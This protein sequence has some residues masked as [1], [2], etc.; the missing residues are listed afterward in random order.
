MELITTEDL[1]AY[2][3]D[4]SVT[5]DARA[6]LV[7]RLTNDLITEKWLSPVD[8]APASVLILA[9]AVASRARTN[10]P[11]RGP[12]QSITRSFDD[13]SRT[14]RFAVPGGEAS[15]HDVYLT[16][17]ELALLN[18]GTKRRRVGSIKLAVPGY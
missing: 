8:P 14:E 4:D 11:G 1:A 6:N 18:G 5:T 17:D 10:T 3:K 15:G 13:S 12:L 9:Y 2:L 7:V 16:E